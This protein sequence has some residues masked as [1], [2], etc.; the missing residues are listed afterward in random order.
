MAGQKTTFWSCSERL[1]RSYS[2]A[3]WIA[4]LILTTSFAAVLNFWTSLA[5]LFAGYEASRAR[6]VDGYEI[7]FCYF[8][9]PPG[10]YPRF[11]VMMALVTATLSAFKRVASC[12]FISAVGLATALCVY[13]CWWID[14]YRIFRNFEDLQ[15]RFLDNKE[16]PQAAYFYHGSFVDLAVALLIITCLV[17]VLDRLFDGEKCTHTSRDSHVCSRTRAE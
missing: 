14:S 5:E 15:F 16:I 6:F 10:F 1:L 17:I 3:D 9:P 8:G 7:S 11:V 4:H 12:R 13:V 2:E